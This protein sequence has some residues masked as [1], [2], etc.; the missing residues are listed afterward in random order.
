MEMFLATI[1]GDDGIHLAWIVGG[2][3]VLTP[4]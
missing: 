2:V 1:G 4:S 3:A